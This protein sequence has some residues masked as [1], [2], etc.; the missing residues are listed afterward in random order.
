MKLSKVGL[1]VVI[2]VLLS[3]C[4]GQAAAIPTATIL[5]QP[6]P[7]S[8]SLPPAAT[9][10]AASTPAV[11]WKNNL[12]KI[13]MSPC[14][15]VAPNLPEKAR[16]DYDLIIRE[17]NNHFAFD[18]VS[19]QKTAV[20]HLD[21]TVKFSL[22]G[23]WIAYLNLKGDTLVVEP[24]EN[25]FKEDPAKRL[26]WKTQ[27]WLDL[28]SWL[29]N[30]KVLLRNYDKKSSMPTVVYNPFTQEVR[31][32]YLED[33]PGAHTSINAEAA[34]PYAFTAFNVIP[35]PTLSK[36]IFAGEEPGKFPDTNVTLW[37]IKAKKV[38]V[39][40]YPFYRRNGNDPLWAPDGNDFVM[41]FDQF[42]WYQVKSDGTDRQITHFGKVLQK[43]QFVN[44]SRS[45][46]GHFL[47]FGMFYTIPNKDKGFRYLILNLKTDTVD[48]FCL[49]P[50][51]DESTN[52]QPVS[53]S[54][55]GRY[56]TF[57][58]YSEKDFRHYV[59]LADVVDKKAY[60]LVE[61]G[62]WKTGHPTVWGWIN[63]IKQ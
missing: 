3:A 45:P 42:D 12:E 6:V 37:D 32:Y 14:V 47:A 26:E 52:W 24:V 50:D 18:P 60:Q 30:D 13:L 58:D 23:K 9:A 17:D 57:L 44:S 10:T 22:N 1:G 27:A 63:K 15:E 36:I 5:T 11:V 62:S 2:F 34:M 35:D 8:T 20:K 48:G 46:D 61:D 21:A 4:Q 31:E 16:I 38:L 49:K 19:Q 39:K 29:G 28:D 51:V 43:V 54:P 25:L 33:F 41:A 40:E 55:D 56:V 53:W 59:V 7:T